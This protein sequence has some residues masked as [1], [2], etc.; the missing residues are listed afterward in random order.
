MTNLTRGFSAPFLLVVVIVIL[1]SGAYYYAQKTETPTQ[2]DVTQYTTYKSDLRGVT[3]RIP[4]DWRVAGES[5]GNQND[6]PFTITSLDYEWGQGEMLAGGR[7]QFE[8]PEPFSRI[9]EIEDLK[10]FDEYYANY[11][12]QFCK[13]NCK[14]TMIT[15]GNEKAVLRVLSS[16]GEAQIVTVH[17][18]ELYGISFLAH[19]LADGKYREILS[20]FIEGFEYVK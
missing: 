14:D 11:W 1:G 12:K 10:S 18:G 19:S 7:F 5:I 8:D 20:T 16:R 4:A 3:L 2:E 6:A 17:D 9:A 15:L 13:E